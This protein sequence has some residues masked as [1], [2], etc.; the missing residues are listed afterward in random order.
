MAV[1]L[2]TPSGEPEVL[3][4]S[5]RTF[6]VWRYGVGHSQLLIRSAPE[7][8]EDEFIDIHFD[9]VAAMKLAVKYQ[10]IAIC[11]ASATTARA[12]H[13]FARVEEKWRTTYV[14]LEL[15]TRGESGH[16]LCRSVRA[17]IGGTEPTVVSEERQRL[18]WR[19][20]A[21]GAE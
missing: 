1:S 5:E 2:I 16:V 18:I 17:L 4:T 7:D 15:R 3:F 13:D 12:L 21:G 11:S 9:G 20:P 14:A 19:F 8:A 6:K 10:T